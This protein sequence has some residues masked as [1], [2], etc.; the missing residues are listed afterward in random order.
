MLLL[1]YSNFQKAL[2]GLIAGGIEVERRG[3][4]GGGGRRKDDRNN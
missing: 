4:G 1:L 3:L 2:R